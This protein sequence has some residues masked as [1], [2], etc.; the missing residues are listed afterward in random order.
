MRSNVKVVTRPTP[1]V[2]KIVTCRL[3]A[4]SLF[5]FGAYATDRSREIGQ[6]GSTSETSHRGN[7]EF[8]AGGAGRFAALVPDVP[9]GDV[10]QGGGDSPF[11]VRRATSVSRNERRISGREGRGLSARSVTI[12]VTTTP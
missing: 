10:I 6:T 1:I 11:I 5:P 9:D 2:M 3:D 4:P 12:S 7:V 8:S